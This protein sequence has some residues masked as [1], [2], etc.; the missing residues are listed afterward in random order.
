DALTSFD[1]ATIATIHQVC[2]LVLR[3]LG[4]AGD[5]DSDATL[6]EDLEQ[7][8]TEVVDDLYLA[9][10]SGLASPPWSRE[11]ALQIARAVVDD[12]SSRLEPGAA[13]DEAPDSS[14]AQRVRFAQRVLDEVKAR[15][16]RL[17]ILSYNDLL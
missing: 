3:G 8:T 11:T 6:V 1:A 10:F 2:Q 4:V 14:A 15:K 9:K 16:R 12:P 7:L 17:G 5:T 13:L